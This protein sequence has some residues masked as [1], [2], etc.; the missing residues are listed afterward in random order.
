MIIM[1]VGSHP[2]ELPSRGSARPRED[3]EVVRTARGNRGHRRVSLT[4]CHTYLTDNKH[5]AGQ[6]NS[7]QFIACISTEGKRIKPELVCGS[8]HLE[9]SWSSLEGIPESLPHAVCAI[10]KEQRSST[11][12]L[13]DTSERGRTKLN[14]IAHRCLFISCPITTQFYLF[15]LP[16]YPQL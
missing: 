12:F 16:R 10:V 15:R 2:I 5:P 4:K 14:A 11:Q 13:L 1:N 8:K 9:E 6:Q 7:K 3:S